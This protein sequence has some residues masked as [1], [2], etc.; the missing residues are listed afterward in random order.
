MDEYLSAL[1]RATTCAISAPWVS[2]E[3]SQTEPKRQTM[4]ENSSK[5]ILIFC[6]RN[7]TGENDNISWSRCPVSVN[8][9]V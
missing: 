4:P 6:N 7:D 1:C 9:I 5:T 3:P 8:G 2:I